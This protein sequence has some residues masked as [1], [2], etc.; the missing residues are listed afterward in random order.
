[1]GNKG[2]DRDVFQTPPGLQP[3]TDLERGEKEEPGFTF[4]ESIRQGETNA[5]DSAPSAL[6]MCKSQRFSA[7]GA[8]EVCL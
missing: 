7:F 6:M 1:M 4:G 3:E 8:N 2:I 5:E